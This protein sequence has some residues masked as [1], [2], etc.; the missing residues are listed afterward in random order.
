M[1]A[2]GR[3][4]RPIAVFGLVSAAIF[5]A[6]PWLGCVAYGRLGGT[7]ADYLTFARVCTFGFP[8]E[9]VLSTAASGIPG[10]SG[11]WWGNLSLGLAYLA[12][13]VYVAI[14]KRV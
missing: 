13:A 3:W 5:I 12:G 7:P 10:F 2:P 8:S 4:L 9:S 1:L 14:S 6:S 11:P